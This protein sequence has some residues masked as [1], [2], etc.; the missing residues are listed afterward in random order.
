MIFGV[1]CEEASSRDFIGRAR[2]SHTLSESLVGFLVLI[3]FSTRHLLVVGNIDRQLQ[4]SA[5]LLDPA[6]RQLA[7]SELRFSSHLAGD[8]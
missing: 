1:N 6:A 8:S 4:L 5:L 7:A 3:A 2:P